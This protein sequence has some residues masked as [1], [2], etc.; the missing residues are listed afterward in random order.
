MPSQLPRPGGPLVQVRAIRRLLL[1]PIPALDSLPGDCRRACALGWGPIRL[2]VIGDPALI[3][4]LHT[5]PN[6]RFRWGHKFNVIGF[7]VG[8]ESMI[9]SDG[10]DH[11]RRRRAV[12]PGFARRRLDGWIPVIVEEAD[13]A[14]DRALASA[15]GQPVDLYPVLR[16]L[17]LGVVVRVLFGERM[18]ARVD[19]IGALFERPQAY[20]ES[21][22]LRQLPHPLPATRR[23]RVRAD[24]RALRAIIDEQISHCRTHPGTGD[25]V[26]ST[27]IASAELTDSEIR[28]QV[29]TLIGAGYDT[30]AASLSWT[31]W[32]ATTAGLWDTLGEEAETAFAGAW[33]DTL[34]SRLPLSQ[35]VMWETLRLH[36]AG[37]FAPRETAEDIGDLGGYTIPKGTLVMWSPHLAGRDPTTWSDPERFDPDRFMDG[38]RTAPGWVPFGGGPRACIGVALA[39][40]EITVAIARL[41]QQLEL[42]PT[43]P[44]PPRP[45]GLVVN[46]PA[47]G[48]PMAVHPRPR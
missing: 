47:G 37:A 1:D 4:T 32:C 5:M 43:A 24:L 29:V 34:T 31:V 39:Q 48:V 45:S 46:R 9:V 23:S 2:A 17:A 16:R 42:R 26:L 33:D 30:T 21:P 18:A 38:P 3:A 6:D 44:Q 41:A 8:G 36:P 14:A 40:L 22:A 25:D 28:D 27:L 11:R 13:A 19:E 12:T 35:R 7:I 10:T 15:N 20:L